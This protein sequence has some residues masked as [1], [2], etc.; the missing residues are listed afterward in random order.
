MSKE[1]QNRLWRSF[2]FVPGN[3]PDRI[4]KAANSGADAIIIDLEDATPFSEKSTARK[5]VAVAIEEIAALP[6]H[7]FVR[8]NGWQ[9][10]HLL[11]DLEAVVCDRLE[12][13]MLP[14]VE[15]VEHVL[16]L[17]LLLGEIETARH[18]PV[19]CIEILPLPE[20][21]KAFMDLHA[22]CKSSPR[23]KRTLGGGFAV[24]GGDPYVALGA[25]FTRNGD[26]MAYI[27]AK[28][29]LDVRA[30]GLTSILCGPSADVKD[31]DYAR[32][33]YQRGRN[34][35]ATG[36]ICIH[37]SHV[38]LVHDIFNPTDKEITDAVQVMN[39]MAEA[40]DE[41]RAV[42][43]LN[44]SMID[45]AHVRSSRQILARAEAAGLSVPAYREVNL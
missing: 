34:Y 10:G 45:Y 18:I 29:V 19:G 17:D 26:E 4:V 6:V 13:I 16:A 25:S 22:I 1:Q 15:G 20:T 12:G 32:F 37:P 2:L 44:G 14:K 3:R 41:G 11:A 33:V 24:P 30:A 21:A 40:E 5:M 35:G 36:G 28:A 27:A 9:Q 8:V 7:I 38:P 23:V 39:A 42:V 31:L 43:T